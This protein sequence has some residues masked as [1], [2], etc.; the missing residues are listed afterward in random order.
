[1]LREHGATWFLMWTFDEKK[2]DW[3][4]ALKQAGIEVIVRLGPAYM[5]R[6]SIDMAVVDAYIAAGVRW[7][8]LGNEYNL[9]NEWSTDDNWKGFDKPLRHIAEW[10][11]R[12]T[13]QITA[14]GGWT[15]TP[16]PSLGGHHLHR[17]WFIRLMTALSNIAN[18]QGRKMDNA[19]EGDIFWHSG[20]GIHCRSVG[21][22][23]EDGPANYDC[24][25]REWEWFD[26]KVKEFVGHSLPMANTE[27][28]DEPNWCKRKNPNF[29]NRQ[30]W[31][32][33]VNRNVEQIQWC[34]PANPGYRYPDYV[35][36]NT[37]WI[38][39][40]APPWEDCSLIHN[41]PYLVEMG[42]SDI[43]P[44]WN[45]L[46]GLV[47][48]NRLGGQPI[49][50]PP[51][52]PAPPPPPEPSGKIEFVGLSEDMIAALSISG[53]LNLDAPNWKVT[54]VEVQPNTDN[55]SAWVIGPEK[56][57]VPMLLWAGGEALM[58]WKEPDPYAPP[59]ARNGAYEQPMHHAWGSFGVVMSGNSEALFGFGLYGPNLELTYTAHRPVLVYFQFVQP[60]LPPQPEPGPE[61]EPGPDVPYSLLAGLERLGLVVVD[62][63]KQV[64]SLSKLDLIPQRGFGDINSIVVHHTGS[65][66]PQTPMGIVQMHMQDRSWPTVG[67]HF[68]IDWEGEVYFMAP[69][70][71]EIH[72]CG[73][74]NPEVIGIGVMGDFTASVPDMKQ[75]RSLRLL[76]YGL[77][78][79]LAQG[80]GQ[81]RPCYVLP[82][83]YLGYVNEQGKLWHTACPGKLKELLPW[84]GSW[85]GF[86]GSL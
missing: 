80:W 76:I 68:I 31:D 72:D 6:P 25:A 65:N 18:E 38:L 74:L 11:V 83:S 15:L 47:T 43:T 10:Y 5:P 51:E 40:S 35:F 56:G 21:N 63:R 77:W 86:R 4:R 16:P 73:Y 66:G 7:F 69:L 9:F 75:I 26:A 19:N 1:M 32:W 60:K 30:K 45:A 50:P 48:W 37:F 57:Q 29:D 82:H 71:W 34:N 42:G 55:M 27:W 81:Y 13:D 22:P 41:H 2:A 14:K 53:P 58:N 78:E 39:H 20:I 12:M 64:K 28:G 54:A 24:S 59:G 44:L 49:P 46:P 85:P 61:P 33:W 79:F 70:V 36:A 8:I 62:L 17:D 84:A 23:L 52:P 67:Y 3:A